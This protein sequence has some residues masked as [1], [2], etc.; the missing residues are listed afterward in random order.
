MH[1]R[2]VALVDYL[3]GTDRSTDA[4]VGALVKIHDSQIVD[5]VDGVVGAVVFAFFAGDAGVGAF[6]CWNT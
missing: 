2:N 3:C 5:Y 6:P 1:T 4:A